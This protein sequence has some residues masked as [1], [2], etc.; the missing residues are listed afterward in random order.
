VVPESIIDVDAEG[1]WHEAMAR[2]EALHGEMASSLGT[3]LAQYAVPFAYRIR[4]FMHLNAREAFHLLELRTAEGGH[5]DYRRVCQEMHRLI[6]DQAGHRAIADAMRFVDHGDHGL[7][8]LATE[9]RAA[10]KRAAA[11]VGD[12]DD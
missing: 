1:A 2:A 10:A 5:P 6:R 12:P 4:F 9:R 8:R 11:G 3:E 7:G